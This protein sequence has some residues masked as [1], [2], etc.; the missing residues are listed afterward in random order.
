MQDWNTWMYDDRPI[1]E[2]MRELANKNNSAY[3][4]LWEEILDEIE[5][6]ALQGK[7]YYHK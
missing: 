1:A 4:N 5:Q 2:Q 7:R 6:K 3:L